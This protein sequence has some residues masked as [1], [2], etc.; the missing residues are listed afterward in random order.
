MSASRDQQRD[1]LD[2]RYFRTYQL[3]DYVEGLASEP[4]AHLRE[5]EAFTVDGQ[6]VQYLAPWPR[7]SVLHAFIAWV[8]DS[9][10]SSDCSGPRLVT[11]EGAMSP[12]RV[13][14]VDAALA[15]YGID[16]DAFYPDE[17]LTGVDRENAY[18]DYFLDLR[19]SQPYE[20]LLRQLAD[21]VFYLMFQNR[22]ALLGLHSFLAMHVTEIHPDDHAEDDPEIAAAFAQ[23]GCLKRVTP[24]AWARRAVF[25]RD[26]GR[27]VLCG[28]DLSGLLDP[29]DPPDVDHIVP[30]ARGGLNDITN[31]QLLCA[32]CNRRKGATRAHTDTLYRRWYRLDP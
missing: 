15:T 16:D 29:L 12:K 26:H 10:F 11:L 13:L 20:D 23:P 5:L 28:V 6:V 21:E 22:A 1:W 4:F 17:S 32:G 19:L 3:A 7:W 18:Y 9:L 24:P 2:H 27:C 25:F 14:P 8:A 30:L 31:L